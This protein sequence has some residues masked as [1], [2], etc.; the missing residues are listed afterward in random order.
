MEIVLSIHIPLDLI[1]FSFGRK[2]LETMR[3]GNSSAFVVCFFLV[4]LVVSMIGVD[5]VVEFS[6]FVFEVE[7]RY[8]GVIKMG[9]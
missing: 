7:S 4:F 1:S 8:F 6:D 3:C 2:R 9:I 5:D